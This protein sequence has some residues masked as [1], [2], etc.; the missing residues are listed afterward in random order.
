MRNKLMAL[1][2]AIT[3][4]LWTSIPALAATPLP[5]TYGNSYTAPSMG[6]DVRVYRTL[7]W[8]L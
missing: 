7:H 8:L 3:L 6:G 2:A 5:I 4:S 1:V